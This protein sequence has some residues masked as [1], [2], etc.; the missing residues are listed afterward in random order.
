MNLANAGT[1]C[2]HMTEPDMIL[3]VSA[4]LAETFLWKNLERLPGT[5]SMSQVH[6]M[7]GL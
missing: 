2:E 3:D 5:G 4:A 1:D 6:S 7:D